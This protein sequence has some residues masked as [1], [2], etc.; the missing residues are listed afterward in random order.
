VVGVL[1]EVVG[2]LEVELVGLVVVFVEE[3]DGLGG[4]VVYPNDLRSLSWR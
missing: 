3:D 1:G 4:Q 2:V